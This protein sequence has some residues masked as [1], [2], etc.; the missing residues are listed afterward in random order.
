MM[1]PECALLGTVAISPEAGCAQVRAPARSSLMRAPGALGEGDDHARLQPD[2]LEQQR[3]VRGDLV[4]VGAAVGG[5]H[6]ADARDAHV[7]TCA[8]EVPVRPWPGPG[9]CG[10]G[11]A[12]RS[13]WARCRP[14]APRR[15]VRA[16]AAS[17]H[18]SR[19]TS[20]AV[21]DLRSLVGACA[22][23]DELLRAGTFTFD[24]PERACGS[25]DLTVYVTA[26]RTAR[27]KLR[28]PAPAL[29]PRRG[30][31]PQRKPCARGR[32]RERAGGQVGGRDRAG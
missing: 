13:P 17:A 3:A 5:G 23:Q 28:W 31:Q 12:G 27:R 21:R 9:P 18:S 2:A 1:C 8:L 32:R 26:N 15:P 24:W 6:A 30:P 7:V 16:R 10:A 29:R 25:R 20:A 22:R 14:R 19:P 11:A 4:G